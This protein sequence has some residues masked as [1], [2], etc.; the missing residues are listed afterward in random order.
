MSKHR[1]LSFLLSWQV[2][3]AQALCF[4]A[5]SVLLC[6]VFLDRSVGQVPFLATRD[7]ADALVYRDSVLTFDSE[8]LPRGML[9]HQARAWAYAQD[10]RGQVAQW[11]RVPAS[12][13]EL[14]AAIGRLEPFD[15]KSN[16]APFG[17]AVRLIKGEQDGHA[18]NVMV[19]G[20]GGVDVSGAVYFIAGYLA[21]WIGL[22]L[23]L[24]AVLLI[25]WI[26]RRRTRSI[27]RVASAAINTDLNRPGSY[28][29]TQ[30]VPS[31]V[32][33]LILAF[34]E[35][36]A[37]IWEAA[38][39]KDR[40]LADAAHE[41]RMPIAILNARVADLSPG[42]A[43]DRLLNDVARLANISEQ[44]LDIHRVDKAMG[45]M[46]A[47]D[48]VAMGREV[49]EDMAPLVIASGYALSW[50][51]PDAPVVVPGNRGA[52]Q[53]VLTCLIQNAIEHGG[54]RGDIRVAVETGGVFSVS[55]DGPGVPAALRD[56]IFEPFY[57]L[58]QS[59]NGSGLGLHLAAEVVAKHGGR[60]VVTTAETGGACFRVDLA[61]SGGRR[62]IHGHQHEDPDR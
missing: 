48:L 36:L 37:K 59:G 40:F 13:Q 15:I 22:P 19:G 27:S 20:F 49:A 51:A 35:A 32:V 58:N 34:N 50:D 25:P 26:V 44:L 1:S 62:R 45:A 42:H 17:D 56:K 38:G 53:R 28:L 12:Y 3:V 23:M 18:F 33:P 14:A 52:L 31:E 6:L 29:A 2:G 30:D 57:R 41:L 9:T 11:G 47:F 10:D 24:T 43:R 61:A 39:A 55:D 60:I 7:V 16:Q 46:S 4:L 54:A 8:R 5:I 21:G